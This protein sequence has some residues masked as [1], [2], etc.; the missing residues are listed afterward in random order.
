MYLLVEEVANTGQ[1]FPTAAVTVLVIGFIAAAGIGSIAWF[2][3]RRPIG[4]Q[5]EKPTGEA[6]APGPNYD[7]GITPAET[8]ARQERE[9][10]A[11]K[12][13]PE[14]EGGLNTTGGY[15]SDREGHLNAYA[16]EPEMYV[17]EP[18]DLTQKKDDLA[19]ERAEELK[20][21]N[22]PGGKGQGRV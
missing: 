18:G 6:T 1:Q 20:E 8:A 2:S 13:T 14:P 11:F 22:E 7:R 17:D 9:G 19:A 15:T 21:V 3:S 10:A 12:Q 5:D 16:V 4:W